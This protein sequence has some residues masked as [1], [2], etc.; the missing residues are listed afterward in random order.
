MLKGFNAPTVEVPR[1]TGATLGALDATGR[2]QKKALT[3]REAES[4]LPIG[5]TFELQSWRN[6]L[7]AQFENI[8]HLLVGSPELVRNKVSRVKQASPLRSIRSIYERGGT[9]RVQGLAGRSLR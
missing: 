8:A 6:R 4:L 5:S 1:I 7:F 2:Q 9:S 3:F